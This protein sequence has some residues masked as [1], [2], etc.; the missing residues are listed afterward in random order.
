MKCVGASDKSKLIKSVEEIIME[1]QKHQCC[2][3]N[4]AVSICGLPNNTTHRCSDCYSS[5]SYCSV[6]RPD[7]DVLSES[8][9]KKN[10]HDMITANRCQFQRYYVSK[11]DSA[12][13]KSEKRSQL[14]K[15]LKCYFFHNSKCIDLGGKKYWNWEGSYKLIVSDGS[16]IFVCRNLWCDVMGLNR[17]IIERIQREVRENTTVGIHDGDDDIITPK[18]AFLHFGIDIESVHNYIG[19]F[20]N[21][22]KVPQSE[23]ALVLVSWLSDYFDLVG[24]EQP[25]AVVIHYDPIPLVDNWGEYKADQNVFNITSDIVLYSTFCKIVKDVFPKAIID[26]VVVFVN[27]SSYIE[28]FLSTFR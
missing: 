16:V 14:N 13:I 18:E 9:K 7:N 6:I 22:E 25:G 24:E 27:D 4:C 19:D 1:N 10:F 20:M 11:S 3:K 12:K 26:D 8:E 28:L 5:S 15:E 23:G 2:S 21:L 17:H